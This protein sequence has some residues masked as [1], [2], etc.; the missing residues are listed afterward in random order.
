[1]PG[2]G[3]S[4]LRAIDAIE[5]AEPQ[6]QEEERIGLRVLNHALE[7]P[8]RQIAVNSGADAG[9]VVDRL[10]KGQGDMGFDARRGEYVDLVKGESSTQRR[11]FASRS[12]TPFRSLERSY[13]P[14][15]RSPRSKTKKKPIP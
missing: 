11:S 4:L 3:L 6:A 15:E 1:M 8:T 13:W 14:K 9:V 10:R 5:K 7:A 12:K 2:G